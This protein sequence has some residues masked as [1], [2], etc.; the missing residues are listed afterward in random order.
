MYRVKESP[1]GAII[2][3]VLGGI[4]LI[5]II[6]TIIMISRALH[7]YYFVPVTHKQVQK[8][9]QLHYHNYMDLSSC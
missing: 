5:V 1:L 3:G 6:V 2:G 7:K 4:L 9:L 8:L